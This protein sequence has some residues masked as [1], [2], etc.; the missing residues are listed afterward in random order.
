MAGL[1]SNQEC[2]KYYECIANKVIGDCTDEERMTAIKLVQSVFDEYKLRFA[3]DSSMSYVINCIQWIIMNLQEWNEMI[4]NKLLCNLENTSQSNAIKFS[5][6]K[7]CDFNN[8][9]KIID[10]INTIANVECK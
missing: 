9:K 10:N 4:Y 5:N 2:V 1:L 7:I 8:V 6:K 3:N